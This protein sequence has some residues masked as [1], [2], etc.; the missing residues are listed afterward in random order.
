MKRSGM[1]TTMNYYFWWAAG[2]LPLLGTFDIFIF[3][4]IITFV[5]ISIIENYTSRE[6]TNHVT[7]FYYSWWA[8]GAG[9]YCPCWEL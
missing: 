8:A 2:A 6:T 3:I 7:Y 1:K 9:H 5:L 4:I